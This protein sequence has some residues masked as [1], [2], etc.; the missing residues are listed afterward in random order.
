[1]KLTLVIG[2]ISKIGNKSGNILE[3]VKLFLFDCLEMEEIYVCLVFRVKKM[4]KQKRGN[5]EMRIT[6]MG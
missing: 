2:K 3:F 5:E 4:I 1:M 6:G